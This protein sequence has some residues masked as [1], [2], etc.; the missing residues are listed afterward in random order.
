MT[1]KTKSPATATAKATKATKAA[2]AADN[3]H[4]DKAGTP[5]LR[6]PQLRLLAAASKAKGPLTRK[7]LAAA[8]EVDLAGCT[9]WVGSMDPE[10]RKANDAKHFPSLLSRGYLKAEEHD[11]GDGKTEN[12]LAITANG[13]KALEREIKA[14]KS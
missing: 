7:Q 2:K 1:T 5:A 12:R 10:T 13:R 4:A 9:E 6:K 11:L 3:G 8:A 14:A